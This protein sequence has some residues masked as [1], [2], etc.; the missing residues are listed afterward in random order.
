MAVAAAGDEV[1]TAIE[2][3]GATSSLT[4]IVSTQN[5]VFHIRHNRL[6]FCFNMPFES[7]IRQLSEQLANSKDDAQSLKLAHELQIL[8][9]ERIEQL[10]LKAV[11]LPL[12]R[13]KSRVGRTFRR[14]ALFEKC[15]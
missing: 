11:A 10:R 13:K 2:V 3:V 15:S 14:D 5:A 4:L 1:V 7:R 8:L 6:L 12:R 9:H